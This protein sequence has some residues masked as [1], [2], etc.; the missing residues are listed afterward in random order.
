[1]SDLISWLD[2]WTDF[3]GVTDTHGFVRQMLDGIAAFALL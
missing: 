1:M 2:E 3:W